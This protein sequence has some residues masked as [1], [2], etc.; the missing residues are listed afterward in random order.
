MASE[1]VRN[2][3]TTRKFCVR[4]RI[5]LSDTYVSFRFCEIKNHAKVDVLE[6]IKSSDNSILR[7][8]DTFAWEMLNN[9]EGIYDKQPKS[10]STLAGEMLNNTIA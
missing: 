10:N 1:I 4:I 7:I 2:L 9:A 6:E 3:N 8:G 5:W